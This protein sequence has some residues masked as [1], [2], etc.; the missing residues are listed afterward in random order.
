MYM[1]NVVKHMIRLINHL[2]ERQKSLLKQ[3]TYFTVT[4]V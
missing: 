3:Q 4:G 1:Y 2:P